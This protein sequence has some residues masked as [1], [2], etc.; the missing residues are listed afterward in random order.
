VEQKGD[1]LLPGGNVPIHAGSV[2]FTLALALCVSLDVG[3]V[4]GVFLVVIIINVRRLQRRFAREGLFRF[5]LR[6]GHF[7]RRFS[8]GSAIGRATAT[9]TAATRSLGFSAFDLATRFLGGFFFGPGLVLVLDL[10]AGSVHRHA[11][12]GSLGRS[13]A[14]SFTRPFA[15]SFTRS[16]LSRPRSPATP[17]AAGSAAVGIRLL[18]RFGDRFRTFLSL[19]ALVGFFS[20]ALFHGG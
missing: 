9:A 12:C 18:T 7:V 10:T 16:L 19:I 1:R 15:W 11:A 20:R 2:V 4:F 13:F 14:W 17:T 8:P 5:G 3:T 6:Q